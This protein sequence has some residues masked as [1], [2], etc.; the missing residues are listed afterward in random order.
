MIY[1]PTNECGVSCTIRVVGGEDIYRETR[2]LIPSSL[3]NIEVTALR[4]GKFTDTGTLP[5][6]LRE[7]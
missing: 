6:Q 5:Q 3:G 7:H 2:N 1:L 4:A